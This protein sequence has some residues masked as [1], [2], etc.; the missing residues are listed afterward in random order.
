V[1]GRPTKLSAEVQR[2]L[3]EAITKG[4]TWSIACKAAG[5]D[6]QTLLNWREKAIEEPE[7]DYAALVM[8]LE[9]AE[10]TAHDK[11]L[12]TITDAAKTDPKWAAWM[13]SR[14]YPT[15]YAD[16]TPAL[17]VQTNVSVEQAQPKQLEGITSEEADKLIDEYVARRN[18]QRMLPPIVS[19]P[20]PANIELRNENYE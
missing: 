7:S 2:V 16:N 4:S 8:A 12:A 13:L 14:R 5:I 3:V 10:V 11:W 20:I 17:A 9:Q 6:H 18:Q 1:T 19:K 15:E